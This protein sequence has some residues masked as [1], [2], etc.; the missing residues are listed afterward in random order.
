MKH[1]AL[2]LAAAFALLATPAPVPA[3]QTSGIWI[4]NT[5][6]NC[7]WATVYTSGSIIKS[8]G[9]PGWVPANDK[10]VYEVPWKG[11][12][13]QYRVRTEVL[14]TTQCTAQNA[15]HPLSADIETWVQGSLAYQVRLIRDHHGFRLERF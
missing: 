2:C 12:G 8:A 4:I 11:V 15:A 5:T 7:L 14:S 13:Q 9:F 10:R 3:A 1:I 6:G